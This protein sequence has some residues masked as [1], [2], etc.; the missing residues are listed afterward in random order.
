[1]VSGVWARVLGWRLSTRIVVLSLL[2]LL[3]V[4]LLGFAVIHNSI[5]NNASSLLADELT[6]GPPWTSP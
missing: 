1:M 5:N 4:Q 6:V 3:L 2:L